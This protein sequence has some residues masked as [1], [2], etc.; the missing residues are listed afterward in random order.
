MRKPSRAACELDE[1]T[2]ISLVLLHRSEALMPMK[3]FTEFSDAV[4]FVEVLTRLG[5]AVGWVSAATEMD[6]RLIAKAPEMRR[7]IEH[8]RAAVDTLSDEVTHVRATQW[9]IVNDALSESGALL[10][11]IEGEKP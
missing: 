11:R 2:N 9:G 8:L 6:K 1:L 7:A 4:L 5:K 3:A 10:A